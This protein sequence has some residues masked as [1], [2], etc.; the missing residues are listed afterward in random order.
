MKMMEKESWTIVYP[1]LFVLIGWGI[2]W[3]VLS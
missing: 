1:V 3:V 2:G